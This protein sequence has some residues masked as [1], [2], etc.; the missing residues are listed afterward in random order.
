VGIAR[1]KNGEVTDWRGVG[2]LRS[3]QVSCRDGEDQE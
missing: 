3:R 2:M 1:R